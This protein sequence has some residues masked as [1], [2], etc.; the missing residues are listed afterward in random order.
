MSPLEIA[1]RIVLA[2]VAMACG[3]FG[4]FWMVKGK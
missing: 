2:V 1:A 3:V 4:V